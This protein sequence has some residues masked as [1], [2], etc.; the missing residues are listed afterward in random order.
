MS[1]LDDRPSILI[2]RLLLIRELL[3]VEEF[4]R[5]LDTEGLRE[6]WEGLGEHKHQR[7]R[8]GLPE[9]LGVGSTFRAQ[10]TTTE[11]RI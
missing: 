3:T 5:L 7:G 8:S 1:H 9:R 10:R 6:E 4:E 11:R 2:E